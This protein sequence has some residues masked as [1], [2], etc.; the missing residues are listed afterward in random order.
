MADSG[1]LLRVPVYG[2]SRRPDLR[3][4]GEGSDQGW[5]WSHLESVGMLRQFARWGR[6]KRS[7]MVDA[8]E[9]K[10]QRQTSDGGCDAGGNYPAGNA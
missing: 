10:L 7:P 6:I 2:G 3:P 9:R 4:V 8:A 1:C 5:K